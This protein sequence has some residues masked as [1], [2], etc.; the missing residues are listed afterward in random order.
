M[1]K[2]LGIFATTLLLSSTALFWSG[3]SSDKNNCCEQP[4]CEKPCAPVCCEPSCPPSCPPVCQPVCKPY[5]PP[6]CPAPC[7]PPACPPK[8]PPPACC[9][10]A[11][12]PV[13]QPVCPPPCPAPVPACLQEPLCKIP[14]KCAYPASNELNCLD[15]ITVTARNPQMCML[16]EQY[17]MN[18]EIKAC[19]DVCD[20][21]VTTN[22]PDG[23]SYIKS[24]PEAKVDG[25]KLT[26]MIGPMKKGD[27][28]CA[29][30]LLKC[31]CEGDLCACFCATATPVRF[32]SLLCAKPI[33]VCEKCGT[34]DA[35]PGDP[36]HYTVTVTNRGSCAAQDVVITDN[37][38]DGVKHESCQQT[39]VF[40]LGTLE[41]CETKKVNFCVTAEKRGKICNNVVVT[42]CNADQTSCQW[43]TTVCK[44]CVELT[45][46]GPK[47]QAIGKNADYQIT[48]TNPGDKSLT[49]VIVTDQ[50][51]SATSIVA[52]NGA[53]INGNQ[54]VWKLRELK[55]GEK[56]NFTLTLT[57]CTPGCFTNK[58][59]VTNCQNCEA[60]AEATTRWKGRPALNVCVTDMTGPICVDDETT[61][62]ITVVNQ[63]QEADTNAVVT[64]RFPDELTPLSATGPTKGTVSGQTV[65][66][67]PNN[68]FNAR[69]TLEYRVTARAK[70]SGDARVNV[71]VTSDSM[72]TPITQ[73]ESTIVN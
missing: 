30:V 43:C 4:V 68:N 29:N 2:K 27:N 8:C 48:V 23:V 57:T 21:T 32:C 38:P 56:A 15:G 61:Y 42:A 35:C 66:F 60:C 53:K 47:E 41:P 62:R 51:P 55:P 13:C 14:A 59:H 58:V 12:P 67:A 10:P 40:K 9:P 54:A 39:L 11:C 25:K 7:C 63:G 34:K 26:W 31:E 19:Q 64:V 65:T 37:L 24:T 69:Q 22:L 1:Y 50:A 70:K 52:A 71:E 6:A 33:L 45:K 16:G 20:A 72:K 44:E 46:V 18:F 49:D 28:I 73:Q 5:C 17:T 36:I 3:C